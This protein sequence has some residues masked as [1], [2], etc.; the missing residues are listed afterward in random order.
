[1]GIKVGIIGCGGIANGKH[2]P[3]LAQ[4][5]DVE[6]VAFCDI[7]IEKAKIAATTFGTVN[8]KVYQ[9]YQELLKDQTIDVVHICTPNYLHCDMTVHALEANKHVMCE[10]PMAKTTTEAQQMLDAA[11]RTGKKL[12]IGYQNRFRVDSQFLHQVTARG[13]L[14]DIY[15]G[16]AHAIR[17]RAVPNWGVF[18]DE[19]AQGGGPL[20]DI[21]TH[22]L[23]LTLWMMNNYE[24]AAVMGS[25]FHQLSQQENAANAWGPWNP[26][27]FTVEDSAFGFIKMKNGATIILE[28]AWALNS[29]DVDEAKCSLSG[30]KGG[31]D[32]KDGL[33]IHGEELGTLYTKHIELDNKGVDFYE[34]ETVDEALEEAK[35][36]IS[37]VQNDTPPRVKPE[38]ALVVTQILEAIYESARTGKAVYFD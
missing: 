26:K 18:L 7:D 35:A 36:W 27:D 12:T 11:K 8:A 38:E 16:K 23:D 15:F 28:S 5:D 32:M 24:P 3:S 30:T 17:R 37:C 20:I 10:K 33:R 1:M 31:A 9:D 29:L 4:I 2:L 13:D 19:E 6:I 25:T 34:G 22:A 21:G 14:G